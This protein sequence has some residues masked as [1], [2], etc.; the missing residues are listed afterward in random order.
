MFRQ[1]TMEYPTDLRLGEVVHLLTFY[2]ITNSWLL[3]LTGFDFYGDSENREFPKKKL[4]HAGGKS[5]HIPPLIHSFFESL[6]IPQL[7]Y[8]LILVLENFL[9]LFTQFFELRS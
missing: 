8:E 7:E 3:S 1:V 9:F 4:R 6:T 2:N 5:F